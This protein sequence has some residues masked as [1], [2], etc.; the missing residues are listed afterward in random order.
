ME[1]YTRDA[2]IQVMCVQKTTRFVSER[3]ECTQGGRKTNT[4]TWKMIKRSD[5]VKEGES[6]ATLNE[7]GQSVQCGRKNS[8]SQVFLLFPVIIYV[9]KKNT[10]FEF[11][12]PKRNVE[13]SYHNNKT[14][15]AE[16]MLGPCSSSQFMS[17]YWKKKM[18]FRLK[19]ICRSV[20][21]IHI[22]NSVPSFFLE[23]WQ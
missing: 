20:H 1:E 22:W 4:I 5:E 15:S 23:L 16:T 7:R 10:F 6:V 11:P 9:M 14:L 12:R 8:T 19:K 17:V 18:E 2:I 3:W 13:S 21:F